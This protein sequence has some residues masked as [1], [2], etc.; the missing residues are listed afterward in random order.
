MT[1]M[2]H[3]EFVELVIRMRRFQVDYFTHR[4]QGDLRRAQELERQV[5]VEARKQLAGPDLFEADEPQG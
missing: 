3:K 4:I 1:R 5:D 2:T